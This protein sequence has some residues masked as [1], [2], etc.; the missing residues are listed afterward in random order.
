MRKCRLK[1]LLC[2]LDWEINQRCFKFQVSIQ[3]W[4][5]TFNSDLR[6]SDRTSVKVVWD[7]KDFRLGGS[8]QV[9]T[10]HTSEQSPQRKYQYVS[11]I[12]RDTLSFVI[13]IGQ[14]TSKWLWAQSA[15][16]S[17]FCSG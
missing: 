1:Y 6:T 10:Y 3:D 12:S 13:S 11:V 16:S 2:A 4:S 8:L 14:L 7:S 9:H 5:L 17:V 15:R